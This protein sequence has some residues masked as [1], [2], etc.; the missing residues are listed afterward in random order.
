VIVGKN[1]V[2]GWLDTHLKAYRI[3]W[4]KTTDE[5]WIAGDWGIERYTYTE[6][7]TAAG[8]GATIH[9]HGKGLGVYHHDADGRWRVARD[10]WSSDVPATP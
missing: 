3:H 9:D 8:G 5:F 4:D 10:A 2:R 6:A 1:A 7:D